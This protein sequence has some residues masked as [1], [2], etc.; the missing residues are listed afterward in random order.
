MGR[1]VWSRKGSGGFPA[2]LLLAV[3]ACSPASALAAPP[4]T[5]IS[6]NTGI[7]QPAT[8]SISFS[9]SPPP[10]S[11]SCSLNGSAPA[12]CQS[13]FVSTL[14][15]GQHT[16]SVAG[17]L[18]G[19]QD[20]TP[21]T[22]SICVCSTIPGSEDP[23]ITINNGAKF[24]NDPEVEIT[25][26]PVSGPGP[27][28]SISTGRV[29]LSNDG[30]FQPAELKTL[31]PTATA[32]WRLDSS[33]RE[34]VAKTVYLRFNNWTGYPAN[35]G[36]EFYFNCCNEVTSSTPRF[37]DDIVLDETD[38]TIE[39]ARFAGG[40]ASA[41][42]AVAAAGGSVIIQAS[43]KTSGV[44]KA[45]LSRKRRGASDKELVPLKGTKARYKGKRPRF[46]RVRD[47]AGNFSRW[48]RIR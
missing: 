6:T 7:P 18:G 24:T 11:F 43:D 19:D 2:L 44:K 27:N 14:T 36:F 25:A 13:P 26:Q 39:S 20:P 45:Q 17:I 42:Q 31:S 4:Q 22:R 21:S 47:G 40:G 38:P 28:N 16:F 29:L 23:G 3:A 35:D 1:V 9:G 10:D 41:S 15:P 46:A 8:V 32:E 34:K 30:G 33:G 12:P 5:F 48:L 37:T